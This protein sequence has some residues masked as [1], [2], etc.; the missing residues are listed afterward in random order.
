M[1]PI[2]TCELRDNPRVSPIG[3]VEIR[4]RLLLVRMWLSALSVLRRDIGFHFARFEVRENV[5]GQSRLVVEEP[6]RP[7]LAK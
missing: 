2:D 3:R 7:A 6:V 4:I 1:R 5:G